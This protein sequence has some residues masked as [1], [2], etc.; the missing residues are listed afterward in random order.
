MLIAFS[1]CRRD[2][3]L[4]IDLLK[5]IEVLGPC[6]NHI[7]LIVADA[8]TVGGDV[9][10]AH[11][12]AD[13]V[14]KGCQVITNDVSVDGWIEGPKSLFL[15]AAQWAQNNGMPFLVMETDSI[16]LKP[17]WADAIY[18]EYKACGKKFMGH[19]YPSNSTALPPMVMSGIGVYS[20]DTYTLLSDMV[21]AG[22]NWDMAMTPGV[23]GNAHDTPMI[24]HLW[25]EQGNPPVFGDEAI[26]GTAQFCLKQIPTDCV[27]WHRSK[28]HSL[29]RQ[30]R[31]RDYPA[32]ISTLPIVVVFPVAQDIG[33]AVLHAQWMK[34]MGVKHDRKA[35]ISFDATV[36]MHKL[37]EF[38]NLIT[39]LFSSVEMFTYPTPPV[40]GWPMAPNWAWQH[41]ANHMSHQDH[42]WLW[43]EADAVALV[44]DWLTK[45]QQE[46][47]RAK[48]LF[49][50]PKV[51]GMGH[52]NGVAVYPADASERMPMA[53]KATSQAWD[54]VARAEMA[55]DTHDS[56]ELT[57]HIWSV[58]GEDAIEVG[59]GQ[60]PVNVTPERAQRWIKKS[61]VMVHRIKDTSLLTLL[62]HG[63]YKHQP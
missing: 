56:S 53:M 50:G 10:E 9:M 12:I 39:S 15:T 57:Q 62:M 38:E 18:A 22:Q 37:K 45:I 17:G 43:M 51:K 54:Y 49:M 47:E 7:A 23:I 21:R 41:I 46:Y 52:C 16:P 5:W 33:F 48:H 19:I 14:F 60:L 55:H 40:R 20:A 28:D 25:G 44:P 1:V 6:K 26:P 61:A 13:R 59:G 36:D 24:R 2:A 29:I 35:I 8:A 4:L 42:P 32:T 30:L 27:L 58:M 3:R 34:Q 31:R 11:E 63:A